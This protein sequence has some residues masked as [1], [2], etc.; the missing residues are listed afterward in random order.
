MALPTLPKALGVDAID[1]PS[2]EPPG[3]VHPGAPVG[4]S[5]C[6]VSP[7]VLV[8]GTPA[9]FV[10]PGRTAPPV[11]GQPINPLLAPGC[12]V[13]SATPRQIV[14]TPYGNQTVHINGQLIGV[15]PGTNANIS[16]GTPRGIIGPTQWAK[17]FIEA[18]TVRN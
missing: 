14:T 13:P 3:C 15:S 17:V 9:I 1:V 5:A 11:V 2:T 10:T 6:H 18:Y 7:T 4:P 12:L 8:G 16:A